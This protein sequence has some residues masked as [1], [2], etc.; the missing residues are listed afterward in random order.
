[1]KER[2]KKG[3]HPSDIRLQQGTP[4]P[5]DKNQS[6]QYKAGFHTPGT[7]QFALQKLLSP[8]VLLHLVVEDKKREQLRL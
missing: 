6:F 1:M 5:S 8:I 4:Q 3:L 2:T 7:L